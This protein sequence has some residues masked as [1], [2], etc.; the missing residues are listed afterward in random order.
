MST[1]EGVHWTPKE[2]IKTGLPCIGAIKPAK[3]FS[4]SESTVFDVIV[5]GAGYAGLTAARDLTTQGRTVLLLEARDRIG[6][7][8]WN[9]TING[10]T[11]EMG[12]TW[13]HWHMPHIYREVSLYGL[14]DDFIVTQTPGGKED[15]CTL[16][17]GE[18]RKNVTHDEETTTFTKVWTLFCAIDDSSLRATLPYPLSTPH[19]PANAPLAAYDALSCADR[20]AQ[21]SSRLT[22]TER[23]MLEA[24]IL[25]M[26]GGPLDSIGYLD[27]LRWWALGGHTATGLNNIGLTTRL[28][29]GQSTLARRMFEHARSTGRLSYAFSTAVAAVEE[30]GNGVVEVRP[31]SGG[32]AA[33]WQA[34]KVVCT[35]PLNVLRDVS[36]APALSGLKAEAIGIG[37]A[38]RGNK[39][40]AD[41][42]GPELVS[43][44]AFARPGKG[45]VCAIA[46]KETPGGDSHVVFFGP[47]AE[48]EGGMRLGGSGVEGVAEAVRH[49]VP[50]GKEV[51]RLVYHDWAADEFSKG[52]WCYF[53]P[54]FATKYLAELQKPH[55]SVFFASADWSDGWRGWI[56]GAVQQ[57]TQAAVAVN[58]ALDRSPS[59]RL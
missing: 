9:T 19:H 48:V 13:I 26:A 39:V 5:I 1:S 45:L 38:N 22:T 15:Y 56:D 23:S 43:Y 36:F 21:I 6:G 11:Y 25:Q 52:T 44:T 41:V 50:E 14:Q 42:A 27:A 33:G 8:T 2:G 30:R 53:K 34:R 59:S 40:H 17:T 29:S 57:G 31:R 37:Q 10:F 18:D 54:G 46:D 16:I 47:A 49:V 28:R 4:Q 20:L 35:V 24:I 55:G 3:S 32:G 7:R 51:R 58:A 12:G